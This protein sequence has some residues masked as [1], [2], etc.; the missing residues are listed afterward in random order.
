MKCE[1]EAR[2]GEV[3]EE[4][5]REVTDGSKDVSQNISV[6]LYIYVCYTLFLDKAHSS[7]ERIQI[8]TCIRL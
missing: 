1:R 7:S 4:G 8:H 2:S 3:R 5:T 6:C